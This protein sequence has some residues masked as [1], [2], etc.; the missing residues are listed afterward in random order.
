MAL[1]NTDLSSLSSALHML[2]VTVFTQ[3]VFTPTW[4]TSSWT[5]LH[6]GTFCSQCR[7]SSTVRPEMLIFCCA[8]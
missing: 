5:S 6:F 8:L 4:T 3:H 7:R 1:G 2:S